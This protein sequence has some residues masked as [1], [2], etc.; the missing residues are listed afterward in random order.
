M[1]KKEIFENCIKRNVKDIVQGSEVIDNT[2]K[3]IN[4]LDMGYSTIK[5]NKKEAFLQ[6]LLNKFEI[7]EEVEITNITNCYII[8]NIAEKIIELY[9]MYRKEHPQ[10]KDEIN[11]RIKVYNGI[12]DEAINTLETV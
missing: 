5:K 3:L 1:N 8:I 10:Y 6:T 12:I 11:Y 7:T 9:T 2:Y 4:Q